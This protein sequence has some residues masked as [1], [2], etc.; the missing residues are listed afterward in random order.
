MEW[1]DFPPVVFKKIS[2]SH[3]RILFIRSKN[4][5]FRIWQGTHM[6]TSVECFHMPLLFYI[7][8]G[9]H[10]HMPLRL[11]LYAVNASVLAKVKINIIW[12][13]EKDNLS[14][15]KGNLRR[16]AEIRSKVFS[17]L[18]ILQRKSLSLN[19]NGNV[20]NKDA[21]KRKNTKPE[22]FIN[23]TKR[24]SWFNFLQLFFL[25]LTYW[26]AGMATRNIHSL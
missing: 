23:I 10:E 2:S 21:H 9:A 18:C 26:K 3:A 12:W 11:C 16:Y 5:L 7:S 19:I 8:M 6:C 24:Q 25:L 4:V 15:T 14:F 20:H 13:I 17:L 1:A 22:S